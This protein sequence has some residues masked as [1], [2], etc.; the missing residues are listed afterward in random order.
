MKKVLVLGATGMLGSACYKVLSDS[1]NLSTEGTS[2]TSD[3]SLRQMDAGDLNQVRKLFSEIERSSSFLL[4]FVFYT[5]LFFF[6]FV[7]FLIIFG[8]YLRT[9]MTVFSRVMIMKKNF[10]IYYNFKKFSKS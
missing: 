5:R 7:L 3:K 10:N 9:K 4:L 6:R 1:S 2:R 8:N